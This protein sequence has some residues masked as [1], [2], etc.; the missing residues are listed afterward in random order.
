[1]IIVTLLTTNCHLMRSRV[2]T[3]IY[4]QNLNDRTSLLC[5]EKLRVTSQSR[6][7]FAFIG[8]WRVQGFKNVTFESTCISIF[9][10]AQYLILSVLPV[11]G[12]LSYLMRF[13]RSLLLF[14]CFLE[15]YSLMESFHSSLFSAETKRKN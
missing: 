15:E 6:V 13:G 9:N 8:N 14:P 12:R 11:H 10:L 7:H 4:K 1:M 5:S 3:Y 2:D